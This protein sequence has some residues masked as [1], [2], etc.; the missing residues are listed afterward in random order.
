MSYPASQPVQMQSSAT[1]MYLHPCPNLHLIRM[2]VH[3]LYPNLPEYG[4]WPYGLWPALL[5][6][7]SALRTAHFVRVATEPE[8]PHLHKPHLHG[9]AC[10]GSSSSGS[11]IPI[12]EARRLVLRAGGSVMLDAVA[13]CAHVEGW[14]DAPARERM[15]TALQAFTQG[16]PRLEGGGGPG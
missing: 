5:V 10:G 16:R 1:H 11:A 4:S 15:L 8:E 14:A 13:G 3:N 12:S 7:L 9:T 2:Q 6:N